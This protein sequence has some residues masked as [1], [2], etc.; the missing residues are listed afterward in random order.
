M[1]ILQL[2]TIQDNRESLETLHHL[3]FQREVGYRPQGGG[4]ASQFDWLNFDQ[5]AFPNTPT[6]K[7]HFKRTQYL[8]LRQS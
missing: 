1:Q 6:G 4:L 2:R 7:P 3:R 8:L 5:V